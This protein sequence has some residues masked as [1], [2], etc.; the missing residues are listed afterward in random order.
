MVNV[1]KKNQ[2]NTTVRYH[3]LYT[4]SL[5]QTY[6]TKRE[7]QPNNVTTLHAVI[8]ARSS[9]W[10]NFLWPFEWSGRIGISPV[11]AHGN[12][13][14]G[15][16]L[17][18]SMAHSIFRACREHYACANFIISRSYLLSGASSNC[19]EGTYMLEF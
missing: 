4:S 13:H 15:M 12:H 17:S 10:V 11:H 7:F 5:W 2:V 14:S 3:A 8:I 1:E 19:F 16:V 9:L 18:A 6:L